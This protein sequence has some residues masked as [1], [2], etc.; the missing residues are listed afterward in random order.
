[1]GAGKPGAWCGG[2]GGGNGGG[3]RGAGRKRS[4]DYRHKAFYSTWST[5]Q[6]YFG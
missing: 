4:T 2:G 1:M 3:D 6:F 5:E